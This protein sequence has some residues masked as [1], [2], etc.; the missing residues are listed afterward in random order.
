LLGIGLP[1]FF[2]SS[3]ISNFSIAQGG[4]LID[5][6]HPKCG[7]VFGQPSLVSSSIARLRSP[8][9]VLSEHNHG[10]SNLGGLAQKRFQ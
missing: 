5:V 2:N 3:R 10:N 9:T 6:E 1:T 7:Q 4:L 8:V